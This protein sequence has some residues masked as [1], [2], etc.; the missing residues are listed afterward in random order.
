MS[1]VTYLLANKFPIVPVGTNNP[2]SIPSKSAAC[3]SNS[4]IIMF[5]HV[6]KLMYF[7]NLS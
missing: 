1:M 7:E 4:T 5:S 3:F 6:S 2:A